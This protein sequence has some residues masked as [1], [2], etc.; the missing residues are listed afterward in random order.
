MARAS[1]YACLILVI[2]EL[3]GSEALSVAES[4]A[5]M[6]RIFMGQEWY[7]THPAQEQ[8]WAGTLIEREVEVGPANRTALTF[9]LKIEGDKTPVY[10]AGVEKQLGRFV[11]QRVEIKGKL[12]DL[13]DEGFGIEIWIGEI[14]TANPDNHSPTFDSGRRQ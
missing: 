12:V 13:K 8:T 3:A 9:A 5:S 6:T 4:P 11:G 1:G 2:A 14:R 7:L 10:A